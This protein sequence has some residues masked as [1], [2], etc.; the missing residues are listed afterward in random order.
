M[1]RSNGKPDDTV[2]DPAAWQSTV[3]A[4]AQVP[5]GWTPP[6]PNVDCVVRPFDGPVTSVSMNIELD[7]N[8]DT[9]DRVATVTLPE[10]HVRCP[11]IR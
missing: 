6:G 3:T 7:S 9:I 5:P 8:D 1:L 2:A 4:L 10:P 11:A